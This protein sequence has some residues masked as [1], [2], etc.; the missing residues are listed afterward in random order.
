MRLRSFLV[1]ALLL[2]AGAGGLAWHHGYRVGETDALVTGAG[3]ALGKAET[4]TLERTA[5]YWLGVAQQRSPLSDPR[6]EGTAL[7][8]AIR[9]GRAEAI[10]SGVRP[11]PDRLKRAFA[12]TFPSEVLNEARWTVASADSRLGRV[13]ARWPVQEGAV[14][15]GEVIVFKTAAA[16]RNDR[17]FAHE[18]AHVEQYRTLG[19]SEFA[20]RY[21][22][23]PSPIE[24]EAR[25]TGRRASRGV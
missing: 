25:A 9:L 13:L 22:T 14:T 8:I 7:A 24:A 21:A 2:L 3:T 18:L 1:V 12:D 19:I 4:L 23:D 15:L 11:V 16:S 17:L 10:R 6:A 5:D 20:R